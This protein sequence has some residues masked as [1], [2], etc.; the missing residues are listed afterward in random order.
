MNAVN[1]IPA[2]MRRGGGDPAGRSGGAVYVVLGALAVLVVMA[3]VY[4]LTVRKVSQRQAQIV[5]VSREADVA[6]A[7]ADA[8]AAYVQ[9]QAARAE[10]ISTVSSIANKRFD[11][12]VA[13][14]QI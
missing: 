2:D 3:S 7:R 6:Q 8:L 1:L 13:M 5:T 10:R 14:R 4:G 11:W 9:V 12:S